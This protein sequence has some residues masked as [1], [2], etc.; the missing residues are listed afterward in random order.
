[1]AVRRI[2]SLA[3]L[4][5]AAN[6]LLA[7]TGH[8]DPISYE[9]EIVVPGDPALASQM[10]DLSRLV[11]EQD[12]E[13][14]RELTL[15][16]RAAGDLDRLGAAARAEGYYDAKLAYD[17]NSKTKPWKVTVK[18]DLGTPYR[19]RSVRIT[20][21]QG[22]V[23]PMAAR[24]EPAALGLMI[25]ARA[26]SASVLDAQ[27]RLL[28]AYTS[29]GYPLAKVTGHEVIIDRAD[30]SMHVTYTVAP[31][32]TASFGKTEISGL[33]SVNSDYILSRLAWKEGSPYDSNQ[34][35]ATQQ[36]L[37]AS[38]LFATVKIT[39]ADKVSPDGRIPMHV[40]VTE[41][42]PRTIGGGIFYDTSLG[43]GARG[44]WEH[45]N[46]FGE[47]ELLHLEG[48]LGVSE[49]GFLGQFKRPAF[50]RPDLDLRVEASITKQ[51]TDAFD[52]LRG[53]VF[54][55]LD[56]HI[57]NEL[58]GGIGG[59]FVK[60]TVNDDTGTQR[61]TL[62]GLP[63]YLRR[64]DTDD[65]LNPTQGTRL[66]LTATP[67]AS[68]S[69]PSLD[70]LDA[71]L[72]ASGYQR[73]GSSDRFVLAGYGRI[74]SIAGVSQDDLPRDLRFY[75]GGGGSVRAYGYQRAGP[76]DGFGNPLGGVSSLVFGVELRTK[77]TDT[78]GLVAF[79]D[80]G[81]VY[82]SSLPDLSQ[83]LFWGPGIG[84]RYYSPIGPLRFD[85]ATPVDRRESD[86]IIQIYISLGQAF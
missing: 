51:I 86:G 44:F 27:D 67:Y 70:Y 24:L 42:S 83:K 80:A 66:G 30:H 14:D 26:R 31:G 52:D 36:T 65:L 43:F 74:G 5:L 59:E 50:L 22:G 57:D 34:V 21:P 35:D 3:I 12:A 2:E 49:Y 63:I 33:K 8:A 84:V 62:A 58:T 78:I 37:V 4:M 46:L 20:T 28:R 39:P 82:D 38:N 47:G 75:E 23:P 13:V 11:A 73:L 56:W 61:Y 17:I 32:P 77:I 18:V 81:S 9:T 54:T 53:V 85:V 10:H 7:Q 25:G 60:G 6:F 71:R 79:F 68:I 72:S 19:L 76:L 16:R 15:R 48:T 69:S 45:R 64:D 40:T 41:R 29:R 55:G 1:V